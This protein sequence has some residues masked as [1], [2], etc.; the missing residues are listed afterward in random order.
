MKPE[1]SRRRLLRVGRVAGVAGCLLLSVACGANRPVHYVVRPGDTLFSISRALDTRVDDLVRENR[2]RDPD[3]IRVGQVLRVPDRAPMS[4]SKGPVVAETREAA[5]EESTLLWPVTGGR[6]SSAFGERGARFHDGIDIAAPTGSPVQASERGVVEYSGYRR[7]YGN[8]VVVRHAPGLSTVYAH[9]QS[10]WVRPGQR[11]RR[12]EVIAAVGETGKTTGPN[13]HFEV[14]VGKRLVDPMR[15]FSAPNR[16]ES[17]A[18]T[19]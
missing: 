5:I 14:W 6:L 2:I 8:V 1:T 7:G 9:N 11:V 10:N 13:L 3:R 12:G 16:V 15:Y 18:A 4:S 17:A 19:Y